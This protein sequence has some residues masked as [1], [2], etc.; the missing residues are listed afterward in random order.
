M[1][2]A[3]VCKK[4]ETRLDVSEDTSDRREQEKNRGKNEVSELETG[5][6]VLKSTAAAEVACIKRLLDLEEGR[7]KGKRNQMQNRWQPT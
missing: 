4:Q 7:K 1:R 3:L 5:V 2:E 6:K